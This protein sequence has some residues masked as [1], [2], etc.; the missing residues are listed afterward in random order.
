MASLLMTSSRDFAAEVAHLH[1]IVLGLGNQI[2]DGVDIGALE[3][4][5]AAHAE[6]QLLDRQLEHLVALG[7]GLLHDGGACC[8]S[9]RK[10]R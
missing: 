5:E 3:A 1:H 6:I 8:P 10:G 2:L 9:R 7:L 4:V